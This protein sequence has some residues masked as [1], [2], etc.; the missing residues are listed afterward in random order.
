MTVLYF[1]CDFSPT[2]LDANV[3]KLFHQCFVIFHK[4]ELNIFAY[5]NVMIV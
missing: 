1:F 2:F 3:M 5:N 4:L